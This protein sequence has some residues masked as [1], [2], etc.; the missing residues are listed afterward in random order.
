MDEIHYTIVCNETLNE[1]ISLK[2]NTSIAI[3]RCNSNDNHTDLY[4]ERE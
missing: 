3:D 2:S 1:N 4:I